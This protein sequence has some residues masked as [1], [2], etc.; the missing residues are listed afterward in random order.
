[1]IGYLYFVQTPKPSLVMKMENGLVTTDSTLEFHFNLPVVRNLKIEVTPEVYGETEYGRYLFTNH[2]SRSIVFRPEL[3]WKPGTTYEVVVSNVKSILPSF[4]QSKSYTYTFQVEDAPKIDSI[5]PAN[6]QPISP[7]VVW[8]ITL[9]KNSKKLTEYQFSLVPEAEMEVTSDNGG[10]I[11]TVKPQEHLLQGQK[12]TFKIFKKNIRYTFGTDE[13]GYQAEPELIKETEWQVQEAPGI[14]DFSPTGDNV[15]LGQSVSITLDKNVDMDS[16]SNNIKIEP[17]VEGQWKTDDYK[18][19]TFQ[20]AA[21]KKDTEY[22]VTLAAGTKTFD[23]GYLEKDSVHQFKTLGPVRVSEAFPDN[24]YS[25]IGINS[26]IKTTF[27]QAV[28]KKSAEGKFSISP[29]TEGVFSWDGNAMIFTP[30]APLSYNTAYAFSLASGVKAGAG[31]ASEEKYEYSFTT[32]LSVT[33]LNVAFHRQE[34]NLSCEVAT[35]VMALKFRG[36]D[37]SEATL[38]D[39]IGF[40]TTPKSDGVWGNPNLAFVGDIDGHQPSTGYGVY[41]QPIAQ[42]ARAYRTARAFTDGSLADL[43]SEIKKGNPVIVWGTAGSG[44][45]IDWKT[46]QGGTV[47]AINGE[48]TRLVIGFIGS[49][50]NPTK[51]ITLDPLSGEKYFTKDSFFHNWS[52]LNNSGV[53]VE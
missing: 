2:L 31:Y 22:T 7:E 20:S 4:W 28:D 8:E 41:W 19:I 44:T 43:T 42:A 13:V 51:I 26:A 25:G 29:A 50:D 27:D 37:V 33:K 11:F 23:G 30:T 17:A 18:T 1:M 32:E 45:R 52:L 36:V 10:K 9:D 38:I 24:G 21:L 39:A 53:V 35:L 48:H 40:D 47:V 12:Y 5:S 16:F 3:T 49:A 34:H 15:S 6:D 46:P 14:V